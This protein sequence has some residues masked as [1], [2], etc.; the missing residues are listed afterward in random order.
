[1][2]VK[3]IGIFLVMLVSSLVLAARTTVTDIEKFNWVSEKTA[4]GG[5]PTIAQIGA[6]KHGI[7]HDVNLRE[8]SEYDAAAEEAAAKENGLDYINIPVAKDA[9]KAEQVDAFLKLMKD[10]RSP[11]SS[12]APP[13]TGSPRSG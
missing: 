7:P 4:T 2:R 10:A 3:P 12:T 13:A 11:C 9:P 1:M 6:L 8:A 5:Q